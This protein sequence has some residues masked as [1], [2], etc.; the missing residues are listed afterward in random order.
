MQDI[1]TFNSNLGTAI[2]L[3]GSAGSGK[4][5][6]GM[7]LFPK[8]YVHVSDFNFESGKR[9][10]EKIGQLQNVVGF[11]YGA[12]DEGKVIPP[13]VRYDKMFAR[14]NAASKDP[15]VDAIFIDSAT[16]IE[17]YIK[18]KICG[19]ASETAIKLSGYDQWGTLLITWKGLITELRLSGKKLIMAIHETKEK[20]DSDQ[21]FKTQLAVDGQIRGKF[22]ALFSDV[23][24]CEVAEATG[25]HTWNVRT[26]GNIRLDFLKNTYGLPGVLLADEVVKLVRQ[27]TK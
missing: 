3:A 11:D 6:L 25:K 9:Y 16:F 15:N 14:I 13:N 8:T 24:H 5:S 23:W 7:R 22:P 19:A 12:M 1:K 27:G 26:L 4:T 20:D 2:L 21:I 18:A 10:L 17:D